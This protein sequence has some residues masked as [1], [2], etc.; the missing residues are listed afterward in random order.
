M[1]HK[2]TIM[3][4]VRNRLN[5]NGLDPPYPFFPPSKFVKKPLILALHILPC[6]F[7]KIPL[8]LSRVL[9][10]LLLLLVFFNFIFKGRNRSASFVLEK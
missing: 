7:H 3:I 10:D 4:M 2:R 6:R 1:K 8:N 5:S 9:L